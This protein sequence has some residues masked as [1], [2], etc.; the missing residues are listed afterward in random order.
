MAHRRNESE[1][2]DINDRAPDALDWDAL[3]PPVSPWPAV[4][5]SLT[6]SM[7]QAMPA[8]IENA[9]RDAF[10][11]TGLWASP[12]TVAP[13][14]ESLVARAITEAV[15]ATVRQALRQARPAFDTARIPFDIAQPGAAAANVTA[16]QALQQARPAFET[17]LQQQ[18]ATPAYGTGRFPLTSALTGAA[19]AH[20]P[21]PP[22]QQATPA[23]VAGRRPLPSAPTGA[24]AATATDLPQEAVRRGGRMQK[25]RTC[26][27][28]DKV[29]THGVWF[30]H[31]KQAHIGI[32]CL[33][34]G[35]TTQ[36]DFPDEK[37]LRRHLKDHRKA[38][39][40]DAPMPPGGGK[41]CG[42][43]GCE[44]SYGSL[45]RAERHVTEHQVLLRR[46]QDANLEMQ[47]AANEAT[48]G[49]TEGADAAVP[50]GGVDHE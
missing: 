42:W 31:V 21:Y 12:R 3:I 18:Q 13:S 1:N 34:P 38:V 33:W 11:E 10:V 49:M 22:Q 14:I 50:G 20:A 40:A 26:P 44:R 23:S 25:N 36:S 17:A 28:C 41:P 46:A 19:A 45:D 4:A 43:P 8:I 24:A 47:Y 35:C 48:K 30:D 39:I 37:A 15:P 5:G 7:Q 6:A 16:R 29:M 27:E 2:M 32:R 9:V